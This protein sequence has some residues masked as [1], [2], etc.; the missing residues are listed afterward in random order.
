MSGNAPNVDTATDGEGSSCIAA[1]DANEGKLVALTAAVTV[2]AGVTCKA[3]ELHVVD[4]GEGRKSIATELLAPARRVTVDAATMRC[5][6]LRGEG[7]ASIAVVLA[8]GGGS[9]RRASIAL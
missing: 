3:C 2:G 7:V 4:P 5:A 8:G 1:T 9:D 6:K